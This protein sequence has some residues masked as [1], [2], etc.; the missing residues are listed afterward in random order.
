[1]SLP[2]SYRSRMRLLVGGVCTLVITSWLIFPSANVAALDEI[3][4]TDSS[5]ALPEQPPP[6]VTQT[7]EPATPQ[8]VAVSAAPTTE[9][10]TGPQAPTGAS[11]S[12][13]SYNESSGLW[14]NAQYTWSPTTQQTQPKTEPTYSYNPTTGMW[15]TTEWRY[16]APSGKYVENIVSVPDLP[17]NAKTQNL[18]TGNNPANGTTVSPGATN[19]SNGTPTLFDLFYNAN[20]SN[21]VFSNA[22]TGNA[23]IFGNTTAGDA[24]TGNATAIS[25]I[26]NLLRSSWDTSKQGSL[27]TF[28]S[29]MFGNVYGDLLINPSTLLNNATALPANTTVNASN[30]GSIDNNVT[31]NAAS[32]NANVGNNTTAGNATTGDSY[33]LANIINAISSSISAGQSFFGIL[34]IFG[35]LNGDILMPS[36]LMNLLGAAAT[37]SSQSSTTPNS[38]VST[39][40]QQNITNTVNGTATSGNATVSNNTEA[41]SATTG[42]AS[43]KL[44]ILNLTGR[45]IIGQDAFLVFVNVLGNWYGLIIDS[46][47]GARTAVLGDGLTTNTTTSGPAMSANDQLAITNNV[48]LG[49]TSGD[50]TVTDNTKAGNA[51]TGN[52]ATTASIANITDSSLSLTGWFGVLFINIFG[53]WYGSFGID[54]AAG[55]PPT[56]VQ[57]TA[58]GPE[59]SRVNHSSSVIGVFIASSN[60]ASATLATTQPAEDTTQGPQLLGSMIDNTPNDTPTGTT[61]ATPSYLVQI[62]GGVFG[63]TLLASERIYTLSQRRRA[64]N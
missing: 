4:T 28:V 33:A 41:G 25:N 30:A 51:T 43:N 34:N 39:N 16:D 49:A 6:T 5:T 13:Y 32:G 20:I 22:L 19:T 57:T 62:I 59:I 7:P 10:T 50:A 18:S 45:Q 44:T 8:Q 31:L 48:T 21:S 26:I 24:T 53:N 58:S 55:E 23:G 47:V 56:T 61:S 29:N 40:S 54:T 11:A 12:T 64:T 46:P 42:N 38:A 36:Q 9:T 15:D 3:P 2:I 52:A 35:N 17:R 60:N 1:M 63:M 27:A 37:S 14:E